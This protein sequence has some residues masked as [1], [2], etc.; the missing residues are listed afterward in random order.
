MDRLRGLSLLLFLLCSAVGL[1]CTMPNP[2][3]TTI[4]TGGF[5]TKNANVQAFKPLYRRDHRPLHVLVGT[6][7]ALYHV[8][9]K[10]QWSSLFRDAEFVFTWEA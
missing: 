9:L 8:L 1:V 5:S 6:N 7:F 3:L 4:I 2:S 10:G